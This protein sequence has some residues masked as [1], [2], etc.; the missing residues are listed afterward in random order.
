MADQFWLESRGLTILETF[1]TTLR[2][3]A[4]KNQAKRW[5]RQRYEQGL[6]RR[7]MFALRNY[8]ASKAR[9]RDQNVLVQSFYKC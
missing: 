1:L 6:L 7:C 2:E 9:K 4:V 8:T 3:K 5:V